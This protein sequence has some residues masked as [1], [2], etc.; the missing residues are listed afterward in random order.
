METEK[1]IVE[2][3]RYFRINDVIGL[4][5]TILGDD[6][7]QQGLVLV[8]SASPSTGQFCEIDFEFNQLTNTLWHESP[9][10]AQALGLL[11]RKISM[12][13]AQ[14]PNPR[15]QNKELHA[16]A[17]D[18]LQVNIS[19][20]GMAFHC[21]DHLQEGTRLK[22]SVQLKP[23]DISLPLFGTVIES[24]P[25]QFNSKQSYWV[26]VVFD[27]TNDITKEHLIKHMVQKQCAQ[28]NEKEAQQD[29]Y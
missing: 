15:V 4:S 20:C 21:T 13:A 24:E 18:D 1:S 9:T 12:I 14:N 27:E 3:R 5:Y 19:A 11:N 17:Y 2:K 6:K 26:R 22:L 23:S 16:T 10:I 8:D 25:V 7:N 29:T 28:L